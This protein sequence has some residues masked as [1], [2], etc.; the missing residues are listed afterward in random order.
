M[1]APWLAAT[2]AALVLVAGC[3]GDD[4]DETPAPRPAET[5]DAVS[6]LP[7]GW[8]VHLNRSGGFAFGIPRG[9]EANDRGV[10]TMIRSFDRVVAISITTD[11]SDQALELAPEEFATRE[12]SALPGYEAGLEPGDPRPFAHRYRAVVVGARATATETGLE[13]RLRLVVLRRDRVAVASAVIAAAANPSARPS[14]RVAERVVR[15]LRTRPPAVGSG[16]AAGPRPPAD[17]PQRSG[18][19]G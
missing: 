10:S 3:G 6:D 9:W 11:R 17:S 16:A 13:Q 12:L 5:V 2:L 18:R 14:E 15:T 7:S 8:R 19:S 4:S 1:T